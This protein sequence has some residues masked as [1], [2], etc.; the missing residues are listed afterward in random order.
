MSSESPNGQTAPNEIR[1]DDSQVT[2]T[3][4]NFCRVNST[5]E[6]VILD[7]GLNPN[8]PGN[9]QTVKVS[10]RI[11]VNHFTAK[12]LVMALQMAIAQHE[13]SFG[14]LE[15]DVRKRLRGTP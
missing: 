15:V 4:A 13:R 12:R 1:V 3:Y 14:A 6:E 5:P 7:L 11:I 8:S 9:E 2:A 10:Q